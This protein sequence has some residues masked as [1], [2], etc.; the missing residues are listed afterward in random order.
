MEIKESGQT[1]EEYLGAIPISKG[2]PVEYDSSM[3]DR[4]KQ[5]GKSNT[6]APVQETVPEN[7]MPPEGSEGD[8]GADY[9]NPAQSEPQ[10]P[11]A[12]AVPPAEE[13]PV[14]PVE[15]VQ[16]QPVEPVEPVEP[17]PEQPPEIPAEP[18]YK[19]EF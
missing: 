13:T 15:P 8:G 5:T 11:S 7:V 4:K 2:T 19:F 18:Q 14:V 6:T 17:Q 9:S 3:A 10:V 1:L 16:P 12:P